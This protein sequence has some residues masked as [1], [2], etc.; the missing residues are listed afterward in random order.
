[1]LR[2][3]LSGHSEGHPVF[4]FKGNG[5]LSLLFAAL[6]LVLPILGGCGP[7]AEILEAVDYRPLPGHD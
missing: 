2:K 6:F 5:L 1:M 4:R 3:A 7:R